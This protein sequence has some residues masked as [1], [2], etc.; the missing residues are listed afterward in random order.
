MTTFYNFLGMIFALNDMGANIPYPYD[1]PFKSGDGKIGLWS[2]YGF[3]VAYQ[4]KLT[5]K[6]GIRLDGGEPPGEP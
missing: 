5:G 2:L 1:V 4:D 3:A 6:K